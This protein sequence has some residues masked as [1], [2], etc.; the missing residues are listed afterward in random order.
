M[1]GVYGGTFD[2]VHNAHLAMARQMGFDL[3][4]GFIFRERFVQ[5]GC[6]PRQGAARAVAE[7]A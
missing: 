2:P 7:V 3:V 1:I 4:Q 5:R 6:Q